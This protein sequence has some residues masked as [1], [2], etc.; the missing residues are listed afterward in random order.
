VP[1]SPKK[2]RRA[3]KIVLKVTAGLVISLILVLANPNCFIAPIA[4]PIIEKQIAAHTCARC[5][6]ASLHLTIFNGVYLDGL[7]LYD[8][9]DPPDAPPVVSIGH[10]A[11]PIRVMPLISKQVVLGEVALTDVDAHLVREEGGGWNLARIFAPPPGTPPEPEKPKEPS[12]TPPGE[13]PL[14]RVVLEGLTVERVHVSVEDPAFGSAP[15]EASDIAVAIPPLEIA[16]N[17]ALRGAAKLTAGLAIAQ[18]ERS[19]GR[20]SLAAGLPAGARVTVPATLGPEVTL[21]VEDVDLGIAKALGG[22]AVPLESLAGALGVKL[23]AHASDAAPGALAAS[24]HLGVQALKASGGA[25]EGGGL[26]EPE[27]ALDAAGTWKP[28]AA[29]GDAV[30]EK[31]GFRMTFLTIDAHGAARGLG[32]EAPPAAEGRVDLALDVDRAR[33]VLGAKAALPP[34]TEAS[35]KVAIGAEAKP[36]AAPGDLAFKAKVDLGALALRFGP[37]GGPPAFEKKAGDPLGVYVAGSRAADGLTIGEKSGLFLG[38]ASLLLTAH[39][40]AAFGKVDGA[41]KTGGDGLAIAALGAFLP[42]CRGAAGAIGVDAKFGAD[43]AAAKAQG[44][45]KSLAPFSLDAKVT[46]KDLALDDPTPGAKAPAV[47]LARASLAA[48]L[49]SDALAVG[50]ISVDGLALHIVQEKDGTTNLAKLGGGGGAASAPP[51]PAAAPPAPAESSGEKKAAELPL[52]RVTVEPVKVSGVTVD[53]DDRQ[54]GRRIVI[55]RCGLDVQ[56]FDLDHALALGRPIVVKAGLRASENGK[57]VGQAALAATVSAPKGAALTEPDKLEAKVDGKVEGLDLVAVKALAG[58]AI[59][60]AELRGLLDATLSVD[61]VGGA[62][63]SFALHAGLADL[64]AAG[65]S[66]GAGKSIAQKKVALDVKGS[67]DLAAQKLDVPAISLDASVGTVRAKA[68]VE[69]FRS[70]PKVTAE[71]E[72]KLDLGAVARDLGALLPPPLDASGPLALA[73]KASG[74]ADALAF[75]VDLDLGKA[76]VAWRPP[77]PKDKSKRDDVFVKPAGKPLGAKL[78]GSLG[79]PLSLAPSSWLAIG[80]SKVYLEAKLGK[81]K[82]ADAHLFTKDPLVVDD[83]ATLVAA[84]KGASGDLGIDLKVHDDLGASPPANANKYAALAPLTVSGKIAS[85]KLALDP[86][87]RTE[88]LKADVA[89]KG[90]VAAVRTNTFKVND[91]EASLAVDADLRGEKEV[92]RE[93]IKAKD[94]TVNLSLLQYLRYLCPLLAFASGPSQITTKMGFDGDFRGTGFA[95]DDIEKTLSAKGALDILGGKLTGSGIFEAL[96][97]FT[98]RPDLQELSFSSFKQPFTITDGKVLN[99]PI[100]IPANPC[101]FSIGGYTMLNG[102]LHHKLTLKAGDTKDPRIR[103]LL[104]DDVPLPIGIGGT[105]ASPSLV[106]PTTEDLAALAKGGLAQKGVD[107]LGGLLGGQKKSDGGQD[108]A[109]PGQHEELKKAGEDLLKGLLG[110][111]KDKKSP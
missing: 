31:L 39:A 77:D 14:A 6:L 82:K 51:A 5:S 67:A 35:G 53:I 110:G 104:S 8:K 23:E 72:V 24:F 79:D 69:S 73:A 12:T 20:I 3:L 103:N 32:G 46:A 58:G 71:S 70:A 94:V 27:V 92:H 38:Q 57:Q 96:A 54:E 66:L 18:G 9:D 55:D 90:N 56:R 11:A 74:P 59:P 10:V 97:K 68:A 81:D 28:G 42:A 89:L 100:E 50:P 83:L 19:L 108:A 21:A 1:D 63:A 98:N 45:S 48:K 107:A 40:D 16:R 80:A 75:A 17:G 101:R 52:A 105:V 61:S 95:P 29:G 60:L 76:A 25:L 7:A 37:P 22:A 2:P 111:D 33:A 15:I 93:T 109:A 64:R 43:L 106:P 78:S 84:L 26:D 36:G 99:D 62:T 65:G 49:A 41:L 13:L 85:K 47:K 34:G 30:L 102:S 44:D 86:N 91:G 4:R 87:T 88:S